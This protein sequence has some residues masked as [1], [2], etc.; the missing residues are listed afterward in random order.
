MPTEMKPKRRNPAMVGIAVRHQAGCAASDG[1]KCRCKPRYRGNVWNPATKKP[2]HGPWC[3]TLAAARAWRV[4]AARAAEHRDRVGTTVE[5]AL[6]ATLA[7]VE[8]RTLRNRSG[9]CYKPSVLASYRGTVD[10]RLVPALGHLPLSAITVPV[11]NRYVADLLADGLS[12][13]TVRNVLMPLRVA[14][15]EAVAVGDVRVNPTLGLRLP[16]SRGRRDRVAAPEEAE[17]LLDAL[18]EGDRPVWAG[19]LYAGLRRGEL[20]ALRHQ[21]V[22]REAGTIR[23][24]RSYDPRTRSFGEPKSRAG[25]RVVPVVDRLARR[26][27]DQP[28]TGPG[29]AFGDGETPFGH[30]SLLNRARSAWTA[31]GLEAIGL[32]EA[33]HTFASYLIASGANAK[34]VTV[35]LG[36]SSISTTFD[37]YGHLF[38]GDEDAVRGLLDSYLSSPITSPGSAENRG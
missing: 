19:A 22:D 35:M 30:R 23:V 34:A 10:A 33:R 5:Q 31:A 18:P 37:R 9:D 6:R 38:P 36:H 16:A 2:R 28:A 32:H 15:R 26:L 4:D 7:G 3:P 21:D 20:L 27:P 8:A 29:L 11:L 17:A 24:A 12:P 1:G 14:F 25:V 13:S